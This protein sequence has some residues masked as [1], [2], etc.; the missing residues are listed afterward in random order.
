MTLHEKGESNMM[1]PTEILR[2][3]TP[4]ENIEALY[5]RIHNASVTA[6]RNRQP[7][8]ARDLSTLRQALFTIMQKTSASVPTNQTIGEEMDDRQMYRLL[9][10][11]RDTATS[12]GHT[13]T[14]DRKRVPDI[15][16]NVLDQLGYDCSD[17]WSEQH[18]DTVLRVA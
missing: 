5:M 11:I 15:C 8:L 16:R 4:G 17:V 14:F 13:C 7:E 9:N 1:T 18:S 12:G 10:A 6:S 2:L 3:L